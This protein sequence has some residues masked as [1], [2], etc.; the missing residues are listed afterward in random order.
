MTSLTARDLMKPAYLRLGAGHSL[1]EALS[2]LLDTQ[3]RRD[4][5]R[6]LI[7]LNG[8]GSFGGILTTRYLLRAI[9]PEWIAQ[10]V[11]E[12]EAFE[13]KLME[14]LSGKLEMPVNMAMNADVPPVLPEGPPCAIDFN[15]AR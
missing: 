3:L 6:V 10:G 2:I 14:A 8:D 11:P 12:G 5:P 1:R 15:H 7:I 13:S 9:L 4:Q